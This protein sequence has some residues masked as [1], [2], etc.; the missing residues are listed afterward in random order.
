MFGRKVWHTSRGWMKKLASEGGRET[1][2][3]QHEVGDMG[4]KE[5]GRERVPEYEGERRE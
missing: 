3:T 5:E 2:A 4:G 1:W